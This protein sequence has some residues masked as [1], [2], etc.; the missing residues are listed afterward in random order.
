M[1]IYI[2]TTIA[3]MTYVAIFFIAIGVTSI[4]INI[5]QY[6]VRRSIHFSWRFDDVDTSTRIFIVYSHEID[7]TS[8]HFTEKLFM[9]LWEEE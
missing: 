6:I 8:E 1:S 3:S 2:K 7:N 4:V 5:V 9:F